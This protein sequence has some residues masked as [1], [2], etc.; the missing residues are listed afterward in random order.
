MEK[1]SSENGGKVINL[2][3]KLIAKNGHGRENDSTAHR[4]N[5][6]VVSVTSG[7]G[8]V[9]KTNI[10][11]N[12]A[13]TMC[14]AGLRVLVL[15]ADLGLGNVD[16]LLGKA[17]RYN[18]SHV[19]NGEKRVADILVTG[20]GGMQILPASSGIQ[21]IT[22]LT[23]AQR[24][25]LITSLDAVMDTADI[26]LID[27]AAGISSNVMY[28]NVSAHD[29][30]VLVTPEPTAIT[31]A[32]AL[33][34]VM[35]LKYGEDRFN[36][37]VNMAAS[38]REGEEVFRQ[39]DLVSRRFLD[40]SMEY[41]GSVMRD[42]ALVTAVRRQSLVCDVNPE[43][44]ASRSIRALAD[45][46]VAMPAPVVPEGYDNHFWRY[47]LEEKFERKQPVRAEND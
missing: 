6:R 47:L 36:V 45:V 4:S 23:P 29:I 1:R 15:D 11:A 21:D 40:I 46:I 26:L 35:R 24:M 14:T 12:L 10:V 31:D 22:A 19:I 37:V 43:A 20:P 2:S 41:C 28:F 42:Q 27:T 33:M 30:V 13:F 9:G 38:E 25:R 34:K 8:G 7:K 17:P 44:P 5:T 32:Y 18:L 3:R 16:V 39:L